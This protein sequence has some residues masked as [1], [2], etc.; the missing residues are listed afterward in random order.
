MSSAEDIAPSLDPVLLIIGTALALLMLVRALTQRQSAAAKFLFFALTARYVANFWHQYTAQ[1]MLMGQSINSFITL[2]CVAIGAYLC[3]HH[4]LRQPGLGWLYGFAATIVISGV[5]NGEYFG[6]VNALLRW[7]L[8]A[9]VVIVVFYSAREKEG[10]VPLGAFL[11]PAFLVPLCLQLYS[12]LLMESKPTEFD[13]SISIIG[14]YVHE[15]AFSMIILAAAVIIALSS[16]LDWKAQFWLLVV[17]ATSLLF[18]NYRTSILAVAPLLVAQV[19]LG[20]NFMRR[21]GRSSLRLLLTAAAASL[22]VIAAVMISERISD[23]WVVM[24]DLGSLIK[25]PNEYDSAERALFSGRFLIWSNYVFASMQ[26]DI[27]NFI[28]GFGPDSWLGNF[29]KYAHNVYVSYFYEFGVIGLSAYLAMTFSFMLLCFRVAGDRRWLLLAAHLGFVILSLGTMPTVLIEGILLYGI[30]CGYTVHYAH[31]GQTA[32][33]RRA[34]RNWQNF[35]GRGARTG[36]ET[37]AGLDRY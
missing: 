23:V 29:Q 1:P 22:A 17:A 19:T 20:G 9:V 2:G 4:L 15:G 35:A 27:A 18:A 36:F 31:A 26:A 24:G 30:I 13:D 32:R 37:R 6:V 8:F 12:A 3:R 14:G 7:T 34:S 11:L 25:P 21:E 28:F 5:W 16:D 10:R 33:D